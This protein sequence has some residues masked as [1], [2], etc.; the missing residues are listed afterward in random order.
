[1]RLYSGRPTTSLLDSQS[2]SVTVQETIAAQANKVTTVV[3]SSNSPT[4]GALITVTVTGNTGQIGS[5]KLF[6]ASPETYFDFPANSFRLYSTSVTFS[7]SNTGT[8]LDQLLVP[9]SAF[10]STSATDYSFVATYQVVGFNGCQ[11]RRVHQ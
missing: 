8:Y 7:G 2:F 11:S 5:G 3:T 1:V 10:T 9:S 6:Y 4:L